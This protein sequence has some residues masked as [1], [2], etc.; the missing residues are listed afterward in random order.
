M[1]AGRLSGK[2][3]VI[4]GGANGIGE[5]AVRLFMANGARVVFGDNDT[6]AGDAAIARLGSGD[7]VRF[8]TCDVSVEAD[9]ESLVALAMSEFGRLDCMYNN[10]GT[11]VP[12]VPIP[13]LD[14]AE[15]HRIININ[16][17]SVFFG[18]KHGARAIRSHGEGG[19]IINT[20]SL[21]A[22]SALSGPPAYSA[23]KA[24]VVNL[25]QTA[26]V[27]LGPDR[28]RVNVI[29][30]GWILTSLVMKLRGSA[31]KLTPIMDRAQP[32]PD[33]G[34]PEDVA[35]AALFLASDEARFV[36]GHNL[37]VDGG[38][39]AAGPRFMRR[40]GEI[41]RDL[42]LGLEESSARE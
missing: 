3:A 26:A 9:V 40:V 22:L 27:Q 11:S 14:T 41:E 42:D 6:E 12:D 38:M 2:V 28:I 32:I 20:A 36:S 23:A 16:L 35:N 37:V 24:A 17:D 21:A 1:N 4:T 34:N 39:T 30:P 15:W 10:A 29:S 19:A 31:E 25:T 7:A 33:H 5:A 18:I 13:D 8:A